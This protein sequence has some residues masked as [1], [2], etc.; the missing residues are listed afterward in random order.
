MLNQLLSL[1]SDVSLIL[2]F[3]QFSI[4]DKIHAT[5]KTD[6]RK[7][8]HSIPIDERYPVIES[9]LLSIQAVVHTGACL[10]GGNIDGN[11]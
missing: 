11:D 4:E 10:N 3:Y 6:L 5:A 2:F 7:F 8:F 1:L 9:S